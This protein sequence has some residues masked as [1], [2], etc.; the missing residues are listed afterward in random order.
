MEVLCAVYVPDGWL[1]SLGNRTIARVLC[2]EQR[3]AGMNLP[4]QQSQFIGRVRELRVAG[5][6]LRAHR[7]VTLVGAGGSG[8]TRLALQI[9]AEAGER[10]PD[11]VFWVPLAPVREPHLVEQTI[12]RSVGAN[13][14][15]GEHVAEKSLLL[16]LDNIEQVVAGAAPLLA[17]MLGA[18]PN[19][20]FLVTSR[21]PLRVTAEQ[22]FTVH[23]MSSSDAVALFVERAR[24]V[25]PTFVEDET[26]DAIC[27]RLDRLPLAVELAATRV[28]VLTP[29]ALLARLEHR[30]PLLTGGTR[31]MPERHQTLRA[32]IEWS[33]DLLSTAERQLFH[34]LAVFPASFDLKAAEEVCAADLPTISSLVDKCLVYRARDGRFALLETVQE[35]ADEQLTVTD[36]EDL[37][38]RHG[39]YFTEAAE[40]MAGTQSWPSNP[41]TFGELDDDLANLRAALAWTRSNGHRELSL[42]LG[43]ALSRYWIDRGHRHD[44]CNWL[45]AAPLADA[46]VGAQLRAAALEAAG[47]LDYFVL[48]DPD[49]AERYYMQS[50]ALH[51]E[52]GNT[53]RVAFLLNR[54]GRI[55]RQRADLDTAISFHRD[56][57]KLFEETADNAGR[58]ATL[59]LLADTARDQ[60]SYA[61]SEQMFADAIRLAR[62]AFPGQVR[63]SLHSLGDLALDRGDHRRAVSYYEASME[64]TGASERRSR[65]LCVAGTGSALAGLGAYPLAA[66]IWGAVEA[67]ERALGFRMLADERQR[68]QRWAKTTREHLGDSAFLAA[69]AEGEALS[70]DEALS[71][72]LDRAASVDLGRPNPADGPPEVSSMSDDDARFER[73]GEYWSIS[74]ATRTSRLRDSKGLRVLAHLLADPGR[75]HAALDLERLGAPG[76]QET[77]RAVASGDA[78]ELLDVEARRAYR[79]RVAELR[80]A[81]ETAKAWGNVDEVG[82]LREEM[83]SVTHELSRA[84]GLGGRSRHAGSIA[85]RA[86]LNVMRAVKSAMQRIASADAKL[87]AHLEATVHTGTVCVYTPDP[88]VDI[89]WRVTIGSALQ[90]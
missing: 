67:E 38:W 31:D 78:G 90:G 13:G 35:F 1:R 23:P 59:H 25:D 61:E 79:A 27:K 6:L 54:L 71:Q 44:A 32:T 63:H 20:R 88:R 76:G 55:A 16:V 83:D 30:L 11:G 43:I 42:R 85:E 40:A 72:A 19:V 52:L 66:R 65:I 48:T 80:E 5:D 28:N 4:V 26:V 12:A 45:E 81:I 22:R 9:A 70:I 37:A 24:A 46:S 8:K 14:E 41:E 50:L 2:P 49:H 60:G 69:C 33:E 36:R 82:L 3:F 58:A 73:E 89:A 84:L 77:A 7:L 75:S 53:Q 56:A 17:S 47:L 34:H 64:L 86:R 68:Y 15:L 74:F 10:Y 62:T 39:M 29:A 18:C 87:G 21:E 57:L 51:R